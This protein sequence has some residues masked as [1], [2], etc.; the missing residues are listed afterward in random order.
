MW[1]AESRPATLNVSEPVFKD[2]SKATARTSCTTLYA[3]A[4]YSPSP[5][6]DRHQP[7]RVE[8]ANGL[9]SGNAGDRSKTKPLGVAT[10]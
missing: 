9:R 5:F 2:G 3:T 1:G 7:A 10:L 6:L 8:E 4:T